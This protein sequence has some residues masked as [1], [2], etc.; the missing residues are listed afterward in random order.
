VG[1]IMMLF[2]DGAMWEIAV[3]AGW[4]SFAVSRR[5]R[6]TGDAKIVEAAAR[7]AAL[8]FLLVA[9]TIL[10]RTGFSGFGWF[11]WLR[12]TS[13]KPTVVQFLWV[14]CDTPVCMVHEIVA[15]VMLALVSM[16]FIA[17]GFFMYFCSAVIFGF[18]YLAYQL[19]VDLAMAIGCQSGTC[20]TVVACFVVLLCC[21]LAASN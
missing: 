13:Q 8:A 10:L 6:D 1:T 7:V 9:T 17:V 18:C 15:R 2:W 5:W 4:L 12:E 11:G 16:L 19:G 3:A 20:V 14:T 21:V